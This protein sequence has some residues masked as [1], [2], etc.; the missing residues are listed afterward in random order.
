[1]PVGGE[2]DSTTA[3]A[4]ADRAADTD[5]PAPR[6]PADAGAAPSDDVPDEVV[7]RQPPRR[8]PVRARV[9]DRAAALRQ[10][11]EGTAVGHLWNR[12]RL[13]DFV[14]RGI[15]FAAV[16]LLCFVPFLLTVQAMAG[17]STAT[18]L[19][20]RFGLDQQAAEALT[21]VFTSPVSA[22]GGTSGLGF[23]VVLI[24]GLSAAKTL[25]SLYERAFD[26]EH[27]GRRDT[28]R[29]LAWLA[30]VVA[31]AGLTNWTGPWLNRGGGL[32]LYATVALAG[33][34]AFW[35]FTMWLLLAGRRSWRQLFPSA[36]A[37]GVCWVVMVV[38]FRLT[39]S[40]TITTDYDQYGPVGVVFAIMSV[41]IAIGVVLI[42]GALAGVVWN[43]RHGATP[44][45]KRSD[46]ELP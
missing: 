14:E 33:A 27:R 18:N 2:P 5:V 19:V 15:Q 1:M 20:S 7:A 42:L 4:R 31:A 29:H 12:L 40:R 24:G 22:S 38:G 30:A 16:L 6:G 36:L 43:D 34:T 37:T 41:L 44:R 26:L 10:S 17:R 9:I 35:W 3:G 8:P 21:Q 45:H 11:F 25:Q 32:V 39:L 23:V 13:L 28:H 46:D